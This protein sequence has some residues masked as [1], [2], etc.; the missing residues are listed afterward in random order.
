[1]RRWFFNWSVVW[2]GAALV[3]MPSVPA[4]AARASGRTQS[5]GVTIRP[6]RAN[7]P[8]N[9]KRQTR[10]TQRK[11]KPFS[12]ESIPPVPIETGD[13]E[14]LRTFFRAL[15]DLEA[16]PEG[17]PQ[18]TVLRIIHLGDSHVASDYWTGELRRRLQERFGDAGPGFVL[19][20]RPWRSIRYSLAKSLDGKHWR[21]LGL[22]FADSDSAYGL[23]G[24]SLESLR[25]DEPASAIASLTGFEILAI[26]VPGSDCLHIRV[27]DEE[28]PRIDSHWEPVVLANSSPAPGT[29]LIE[30]EGGGSAQHCTQ[31]EP[32]I[33]RWGRTNH[34]A[35]GSARCRPPRPEGSVLDLLTMRNT[36]PLSGGL[37]KVSVR[38]GCAG[39]VRLL[40]MELRSGSKG[41]LYD[42]EG[43]NGARLADLEK[44]ALELRQALLRISSPALIILS[45]GTNDIGARDFDSEIY[46]E[47]AFRILSRLKQDAG[48]ASILVTGPPDRGHR[49]KKRRA[50]VMAAQTS[51]QPALRRAAL[52]AGC[53]FWDAQAAM[54]GR[55]SI[56][57]WVKAGLA[58]KD[59]V[60]FSGPGYTKLAELLHQQLIAEY[61]KFRRADS[62][63]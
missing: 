37:H 38:T 45:Y 62:N 28:F 50:A 13:G 61:D 21:T 48:E 35:D 23:S 51:L 4:R 18:A 20:G 63:P 53:A 27:D 33:S 5:S 11:A 42:A 7:S 34:G 32:A 8:G 24:V 25:K 29:E 52:R 19:P 26:T 49:R 59:H 36:E 60:H 9:T 1:M 58:R 41:I 10:T 43:V 16:A 40:G 22:K 47:K 57:Y 14:P 46:E 2:V 12:L 54:G 55:G 3:L 17:T 15:A 6:A 39:E 56:V 44:P 31:N 30:Q